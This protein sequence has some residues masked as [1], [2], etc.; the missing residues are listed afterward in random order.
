MRWVR[1]EHRGKVLLGIDEEKGV[2]HLND[3]N[4]PEELAQAIDGGH[5]DRW[6]E[7]QSLWHPL[8]DELA[9]APFLPRPEVRL[10][11]PFGG[12][13]K[14]LFCVGRNYKAH[15]EESAGFFGTAPGDLPAYPVFF[16]KPYTAIIGP[17]EAIRFSRRVTQAVDYEGELAVV[18]GRQG[19]NLRE[20]EAMDYVF[21]FTILNDVSARDV[22]KRHG[23]YFKGK[24]LDT[25]APLGPALV[26]KEDLPPVEELELRTWVNGE[27]RQKAS[28]KDLLFSIPQLLASLSEGM[29]LEPGDILATGTPEGVGL[30]LQPPQFLKG[31]DQVRIAITGIGVLENRVQE[32]EP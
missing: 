5:M 19:R 21:G 4:L 29:T 13:R 3:L 20:E 18:I 24:S 2:R 11:A 27:L 22:Q 6:I 31:G 12:R 9:K 8:R 17:G 7:L 23:Q 26:E 1:Y 10:L 14:N 30:G 15:A 16:T 25:F 28:P 32:E